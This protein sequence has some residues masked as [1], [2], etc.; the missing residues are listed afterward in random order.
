M[1]GIEGSRVGIS[2]RKMIAEPSMGEIEYVLAMGKVNDAIYP[3]GLGAV[4]KV[5]GP[6]ATDQGIAAA[7]ANHRIAAAK[8]DDEILARGAGERVV[9]RVT[10][11]N[12][13]QI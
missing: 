5:I 4:T 13:H 9:A 8:T 2:E 3:I 1:I 6:V 7:I 11:N 12:W 10:K